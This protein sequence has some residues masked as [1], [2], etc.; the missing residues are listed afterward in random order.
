MLVGLLAPPMGPD[1]AFMMELMGVYAWMSLILVVVTA[2]MRRAPGFAV[3]AIAPLMLT[4]AAWGL[5]NG[6][7]AGVVEA[8]VPVALPGRRTPRL[9]DGHLLASRRVTLFCC[10]GQRLEARIHA[11]VRAGV[12]CAGAG[13]SRQ[14]PLVALR[15]DAS[16]ADRFSRSHFVHARPDSVRLV[17]GTGSNTSHTVQTRQVLATE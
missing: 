5:W 15:N 4:A 9:A 8:P 16:L 7:P 13:R 11:V 1:L 17:G 14:T 6:E 12:R 10:A 2:L 3:L